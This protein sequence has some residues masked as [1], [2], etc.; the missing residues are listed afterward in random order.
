MKGS[1]VESESEDIKMVAEV[2]E[3]RRCHTGDFEDEGA[4]SKGM[5]VASGGAF[6]GHCG[7]RLLSVTYLFLFLSFSVSLWENTL[8]VQYLSFLSYFNLI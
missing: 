8:I 2:R 7:M 3:E 4:I 5:W 6:P 1:G